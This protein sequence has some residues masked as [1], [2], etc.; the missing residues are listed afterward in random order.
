MFETSI[1]GP[2]DSYIVSYKLFL[3]R[4]I[5]VRFQ[6]SLCFRCLMLVYRMLCD[7][8]LK[9]NIMILVTHVVTYVSFYLLQN[10]AR[11]IF[12]LIMLMCSF[13]DNCLCI[14]IPRNFTDSSL[15]YLPIWLINSLFILALLKHCASKLLFFD[16][17]I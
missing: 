3:L 5:F 12:E 15:L 17:Q 11:D 7:C 8:A 9:S 4:H 16:I 2:Y 13:H 14:C 1:R 6:I 10:M